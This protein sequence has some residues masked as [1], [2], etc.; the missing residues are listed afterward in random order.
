MR[1]MSLLVLGFGFLAVGCTPPATPEMT[2]APPPASG[3]PTASSGSTNAMLPS[4]NLN[5]K[6]VSMKVSMH[7]PHGCYPAVKEALEKEAGVKGV[8]LAKQK[9]PDAI[10]NPIVYISVD[11]SFDSARAIESLKAAG[12]ESEVN[13]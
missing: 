13:N 12:F 4:S 8:E 2:P 5:T 7:C 11:S 10:D 1:L 6:L 9:D 3:T